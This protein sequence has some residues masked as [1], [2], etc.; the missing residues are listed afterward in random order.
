M[1]FDFAMFN[2]TELAVLDSTDAVGLP[3][4]GASYNA[5]Y[6]EDLD[7]LLGTETVPASSCC[8]SCCSSSSC[9]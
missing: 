9:C 5:K 3:E 8:S 4:M 6:V 1:S 7:D 2:L